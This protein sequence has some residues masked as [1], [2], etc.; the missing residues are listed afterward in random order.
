MPE[1][2]MPRCVVQGCGNSVSPEILFCARCWS[3]VPRHIQ[4]SLCISERL[5][6]REVEGVKDSNEK[7]FENARNHAAAALGIGYIDDDGIGP[8]SDTEV[9]P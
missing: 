6:E 2:K 9:A 1:T 3:N 5:I 8:Q 4:Q 7:A